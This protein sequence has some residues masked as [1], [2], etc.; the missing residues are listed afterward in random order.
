MAYTGKLTRERIVH[1]A[2]DLLNESGIDA[3]SL[4]RIA[5]RLGVSAPSLAR[6][7]GDKGELLALLARTVFDQALDLIPP[8]LTGDAWLEAFG[9]AL[10][11]KQSETRDVAA[12]ISTAPPDEAAAASGDDGPVVRLQAMMRAA[13]LTDRQA[14]LRQGA[15][16]ALVTGWMTFEKSR[17]AGGFLA[18]LP[19]DDAFGESLKALIA[20]FAAA[21]GADGR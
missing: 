1:E 18:S 7:V 20:G 15:V 17:R 16:Q 13:G 12:L 21:R 9:R 5:Q 2:I 11:A 6:H 8:G 3:V 4:R 10:R 19:G 14:Q